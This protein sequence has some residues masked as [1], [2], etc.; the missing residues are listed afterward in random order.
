ME[1]LELIQIWGGQKSL[2]PPL[3]V[4]GVDVWVT[5][6]GAAGRGNIEYI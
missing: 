4:G 5:R 6:L 1:E 3:L 2:I